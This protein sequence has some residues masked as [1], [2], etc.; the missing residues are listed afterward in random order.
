MVVPTPVHS[1]TH[2]SSERLI[3]SS[4]RVGGS[5]PW[6]GHPP[7][8]HLPLLVSA[9]PCHTLLTILT[10]HDSTIHFVTFTGGGKY[11]QQVLKLRDLP[12]TAVTFISERAV[13][14]SGHDFNPM[15]FASNG[16]SWSYFDRLEKRPEKVKESATGGVAAAR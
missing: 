5:L 3:A 8:A 12:L 6:L 14:A 15:I 13:V 7:E 4:R 1:L 2:S 9:S 10:A 11:N 16:A